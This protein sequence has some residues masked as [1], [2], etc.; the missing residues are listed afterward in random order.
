M[1]PTNQ[2]VAKIT[3]FSAHF[4]D[5]FYEMSEV[6]EGKERGTG[7]QSALA[8]L[9]ESYGFTTVSIVNLMDLLKF[10][11]Q[12]EAEGKA[13]IDSEHF[14]KMVAYYEEYGGK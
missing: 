10:L 6:S 14:K 2:R 13:V 1:A 3:C 4:T 9:A 11:E 8:E 7:E 12:R 5:D